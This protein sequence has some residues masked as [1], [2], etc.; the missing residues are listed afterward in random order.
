MFYLRMLMMVLSFV[1]ASLY[2]MAITVVRRDRSLV[3][4]DY[5][6]ALERLM[7]PALGVR[8][9]V[10]GGENL[11]ASRPCV[12]VSNHQSA[13]DVPVL[14]GIY[15]EGTVLIAKKELRS[16][17]LFGWLYEATGNLL[18]DRSSNPGS[19]QR[20]KE[21][22]TAIRERGVSVWIFP[23]GTRGKVPGKLLPFKKG[24]FYMA[25]AAG[26][27]V[28]PVVVSPIAPLFH[29][30]RRY[31]RKGTVQIRVLDPLP[32]R[33]L[34]EADVNGFLNEVQTKM[35]EALDEL[36]T[37]PVGAAELQVETARVSG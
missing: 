20:L 7:Q 36:R 29:V 22:E 18:I 10:I 11:R 31:I 14:A 12:Y 21:A 19:I 6:R 4:R 28:V 8:V 33:G 3:A 15:P 26:A 5:A 34:G 35:Q 24:A 9:E 17:P 23:E 27:P 25:I 37:T 16:I 1:T 30:G 2:A 13:Y 32:T